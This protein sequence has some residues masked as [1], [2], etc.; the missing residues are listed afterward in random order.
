MLDCSQLLEGGVNFGSDKISFIINRVLYMTVK[1]TD[2]KVIIIRIIEFFWTEKISI[3]MS[4]EKNPD[5]KG[6]PHK[7]MFAIM[8]NDED[9]EN[10]LGVKQ[11]IRRSW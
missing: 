5:K 2:N 7:L 9:K 10:L 1:E 4:L 3:I 6:I 8:E 11:L